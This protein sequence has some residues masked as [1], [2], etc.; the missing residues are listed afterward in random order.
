MNQCFSYTVHHSQEY[1]EPCKD[2]NI[3]QF[4]YILLWYISR[5]PLWIEPF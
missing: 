4:F 2:Y 5:V 1:I 3:A